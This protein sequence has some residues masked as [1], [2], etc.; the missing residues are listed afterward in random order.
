MNNNQLPADV[1][2]RIKADAV[3]SYPIPVKFSD[4]V[5]CME[6]REGY[7]AGA[8]AYATKLHEAQQEKGKA[9]DLLRRLRNITTWL[10]M[11][12]TSA[13]LRNEIDDFLK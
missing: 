10:D 4:Q 7:I 9:V 11:P 12:D 5:A 2:E 3:K 8:T 13:E 1:Q 6:R